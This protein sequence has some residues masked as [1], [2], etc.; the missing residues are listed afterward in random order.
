MANPTITGT[1]AI[2]VGGT[3]QL[4]GSGTATI[5]NPWLTSNASV[6]TVSN[7]GLISAIAAGTSTITYTNANGCIAQVVVTVNQTPF[8]ST[9]TKSIC[10]NTT[11]TVSPVSGV[12]G[13]IVPAGT[14]YTWTV[15]DNINVTGES[16]EIIGLADISQTLVNLSNLP[17][18][19]TY[20]VIPIGICRGLPF[21]VTVTVNVAPIQFPIDPETE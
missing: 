1:T 21:T 16:N 6:A 17:Q 2:C 8:V 5:I 10:S 15:V 4:S 14:T 13:N 9:Q 18:I 12:N 7:T 19:V 11:F 3:S 20:T